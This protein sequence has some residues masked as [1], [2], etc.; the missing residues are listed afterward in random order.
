MRWIAVIAALAVTGG[1]LGL[2]QRPHH[3]HGSAPSLE[4]QPVGLCPPRACKPVGLAPGTYP[5]GTWGLPGK[6][7]IKV[8]HPEYAA[9]GY[10]ATGDFPHH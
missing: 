10:Q 7:A 2:T 1:T 9:P 4:G 5:P 8:G 3:H 6:I